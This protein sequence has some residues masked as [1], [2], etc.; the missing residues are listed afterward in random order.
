MHGI[1]MGPL[2]APNKAVP[3]E[4]LDHLGWN[5]TGRQAS[6]PKPVFGICRVDVDGCT[7]RVHA[8]LSS[9]G[10]RAAIISTRRGIYIP[11]DGGRQR[12]EILGD[13]GEV[14]CDAVD[15]RHS[16]GVTPASRQPNNRHQPWGDL[17]S[18]AIS[19]HFVEKGA[20]ADAAGIA[21]PS[22]NSKARA[23]RIG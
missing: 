10:H 11:L 15:R 6:I 22:E 4:D 8:R 21:L 13:L 5:G 17:A 16:D 23:C 3:L 19:V 9:I 12:V 20:V 14:L 1:V 18:P 2:P 7:P